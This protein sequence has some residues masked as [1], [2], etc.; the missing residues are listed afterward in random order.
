MS[1]PVLATPEELASR[2]SSALVGAF[3]LF[4]I[5]IGDQLG[6]YRAL[7]EGAATAAQLAG[8]TGT[9][10]RY[11]RE[12]LEQQA[13]SGILAVDDPTRPAWDRVYR[14]PEG[15]GALFLDQDSPLTMT[16]AAQI[17]VGTVKPLPAVLEAFRTG[18]GVPYEDYGA[19]LAEGQANFNRP[20]F[21]HQLAQTYIPAMPDIH[22]RLLA[23]PPARIA[24][25][26][27]GLGWSSIALA[28][29]YPAIRV[30]GY[31]L[32][33]LS[34]RM[35]RTNAEAE[36]V[37]NRVTF[38][39]RDAGDPDLAGAY[40]FALAIEC[41]HDMADPVSALRA[42]HRLVGPGG[43]A[44]VVDERAEDAFTA[45]GSDLERAFYGFSILHCLPV[46]MVDQPSAGT[47]A[48]MRPDTFRAYAAEAGFRQVDVLPV[49]SDNFYFY[50]LTA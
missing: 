9:A 45:P 46:G 17:F 16:A 48:V 25:I 38:H 27:M 10:E 42:M 13:V 2:L 36:G 37:S 50:R 3:D 22:D 26:G 5:Y 15:Y 31:D 1:T 19:D 6:Y 11:A 24:D 34:V 18:G 40:D 14:L 49:E 30:D 21:V 12:W 7:G 35:A 43:T 20:M 32:D 28:K 41:I 47:G 39:V 8:R 33:H 23:Q 4:A 29:G 44:L